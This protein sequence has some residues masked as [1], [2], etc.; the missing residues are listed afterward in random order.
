MVGPHAVLVSSSHQHKGI[1]V[2]MSSRDH[3]MQPLFIGDDVWIGANAFIKGGITIGQGT[4]IA[5]GSS[6]LKDIEE[7]QIV[8]GVPAHV[9]GNRRDNRDDPSDS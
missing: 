8:G 6:V 3:V 2:P 9:I 4:V 7:Y 1:E 5:A